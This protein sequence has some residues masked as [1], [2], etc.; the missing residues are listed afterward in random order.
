MRALAYIGTFLRNF[1]PRDQTTGISPPQRAR[2]RRLPARTWRG[3]SPWPP[4]SFK[5]GGRTTR[6]L[7]PGPAKEVWRIS[8]A[9]ASPLCGPKSRGVPPRSR[10]IAGFGPPAS[11]PAAAR[12]SAASAAHA[13]PGVGVLAPPRGRNG[14]IQERAGRAREAPIG[15]GPRGRRGRHRGQGSVD[16]AHGGPAGSRTWEDTRTEGGCSCGGPRRCAS[17]APRYT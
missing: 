5:H 11:Q 16:G 15:G 4:S 1:R 12:A 10:T 8:R 13:R 6:P 14:R 17:S 7:S 9:E 2:P 3:S